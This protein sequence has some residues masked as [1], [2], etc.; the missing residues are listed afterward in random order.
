MWA[1]AGHKS[2]EIMS[3]EGQ[4]IVHPD[5]TELEWLTGGTVR[6]VEL[7][8]STLA[9]VT[10]RYGRPAMWFKDHPDN[11]ALRWPLKREDFP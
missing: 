2:G 8:G 4:M 3:F 7:T 11:A 9:E 6:I 10:D 5:R 1:M